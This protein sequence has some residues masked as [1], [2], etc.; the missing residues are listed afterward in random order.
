MTEFIQYK[1]I[2]TRRLYKADAI[3]WAYKNVRERERERE[4]ERRNQA[5]TIFDIIFSDFVEKISPFFLTLIYIASRIFGRLLIFCRRLHFTDFFVKKQQC[6]LSA[7]R[8]TLHCRNEARLLQDLPYIAAMKLK[9]YNF[10][11]TL[12][13]CSSAAAKFVLHCSNV[14][15]PL[16]NLPYIATMKPKP[17]KI[18]TTLHVFNA[19]KSSFMQIFIPIDKPKT[20]LQILYRNNLNYF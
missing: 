2:D 8:F 14:A 1:Q 6:S 4:R 19:Y 20:G 16:Q 11:S 10:C 5:V 17:C 7:A 12:Q 18:Y 3:F 9:S 13:Q 15:P